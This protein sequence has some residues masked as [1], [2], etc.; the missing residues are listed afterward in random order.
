MAAHFTV[1]AHR[2]DP[3]LGPIAPAGSALADAVEAIGGG[4]P[5]GVVAPGPRPAWSWASALTA[6]AAAFQHELTLAG[7]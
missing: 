3:T 4:R 6:G 2:L 1:W 5:G 7:A